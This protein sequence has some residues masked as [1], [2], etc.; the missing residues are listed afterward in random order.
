[1]KLIVMG[2]LIIVNLVLSGSVFTQLQLFGVS[3]DIFMCIIASILCIENRV[4]SVIFAIIGGLFMDIIFANVIGF[5]TLQYFLGSV[6]MYYVAQ[7][8][9]RE[10]FIFPSIVAG[11]GLAIKEII[12]AII[13]SAMGYEFNV[14]TLI[15]RYILPSMLTTALIAII[16]HFLMKRLYRFK[17]MTRRATTEFLDNL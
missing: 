1:M 12:S 6:A 7:R 9:Y 17:F 14:F 15:L 3:P 4:N 13:V 5:Y 16:I 8:M 2:L 11:I 10:S